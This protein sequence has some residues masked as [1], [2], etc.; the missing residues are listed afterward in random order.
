MLVVA[1]ISLKNLYPNVWD[2]RSEYFT[3]DLRAIMISYADFFKN[4][5][6]RKRAMDIGL[7]Q[8]LRV[9]DDVKIY[10]D[11][12]AFYFITHGGDTPKQDYE[13][14][15]RHAKP[16]WWPIPQDFIPIPKMLQEEQELCFK[17]TMSMN[18]SYQH[19]GFV[20]IIH[21]C[22][23]LQD[24]IIAVESNS[25]LSRKQTIALG[26]IVPNLLRAPEAIPHDEILASLMRVRRVFADKVLHVF[27]LGGTATLH[28]AELVGIDSVDSSGW[29]NRAA[30]GIVQLPGSG[31][32]LVADLGKW[33]GR[34]PSVKEWEMLR[35]CT[36]PACRIY[37]LNGLKANKQL[38][39]CNRASH[40]LAIL[41][42]EV[43]WI[44]S[45]VEDNT[46]FEMYRE[47]LDNSIYRPLVDSL[48]QAKTSKEPRQNNF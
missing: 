2:K 22:R 19:D 47:R 10:L 24:Y 15:V 12:G 5:A 23:Y 46:Y 8:Y 11:N 29:R 26:G 42:R 31:D 36:C 34:E 44:E 27:G 30:R 6:A 25:Q 16:D 38:G 17:R 40:N 18:E 43:Q 37:G 41:L 7:H 33:R 21:V 48:V 20:P 9:P 32:R 35:G 1:G 3:P 45:H 14:F 39:F 28:I 13:E 4:K